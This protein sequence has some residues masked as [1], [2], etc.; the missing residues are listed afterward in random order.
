MKDLALIYS[1]SHPF[2]LSLPPSPSSPDLFEAR[3]DAPLDVERVMEVV[4]LYGVDVMSTGDV[5]A[6]FSDYAPVYVEW[7]D[8]SSC[9]YV[10]CMIHHAASVGVCL[11]VHCVCDYV[12]RQGEA[13]FGTD[14]SGVRLGLG[15][16][17]SQSVLTPFTLPQLRLRSGTRSALPRWLGPPSPPLITGVSAPGALFLLLLFLFFLPVVM[18]V[19]MSIV[20][21]V[22]NSVMVFPR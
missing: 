3:R 2:C 12:P 10:S 19:N 20:N 18:I 1:A 4:H 9:E 13:V 11:C 15:S 8:D 16:P 7:I 6:Y 5:F 22:K 14:Y 17:P 21:I